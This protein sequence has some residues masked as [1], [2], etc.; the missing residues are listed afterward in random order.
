MQ[1]YTLD[2]NLIYGYNGG[3]FNHTEK[4]NEN[5]L[6]CQ[7][8]RATRT[9]LSFKEECYNVAQILASDSDKLGRT[10]TVM[11]SGGFDSEV[12]AKSFIDTE[13]PFKAVT[14]RLKHGLNN[15]ELYFIDKFVRRHNIDVEYI[16]IDL[17]SWLEST[18]AIDRYEIS[19][20]Y[21]AEMLPH[22]LLMDMIWEDKGLP[23]MGNGDLYV[24]RD[25]NP[26]WRMN[27]NSAPK[28]IWNY[29]E[30]EPIL[31]WFR[32]GVHR[33]ILGGIGFFQ[34]TP[35]ITLSMA[36]EPEIYEVCT[37]CNPY[38]M[39]SRSTKYLVYRK[40]WPDLL[41]RMKFDGAELTRGLYNKFM[42][43]HSSREI[44]YV[45]AWTKPFVEFIDS[46][47]PL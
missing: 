24:I 26:V 5:R 47:K 16:D 21:F 29:I 6:E 1:P 13:I 2:N 18:D 40:Y 45:D 9:P 30:F 28:F 35:E 22:M 15:H 36:Q 17:E 14:F 39:S 34:H 43:K 20:C 4:K 8:A 27:D 23:I 3:L 46:I 42:Y 10:P 41:Q 33:K 38:K 37:D 44:M 7:Y 31:A 19:G 11:L 12:V 25:L 32:Y